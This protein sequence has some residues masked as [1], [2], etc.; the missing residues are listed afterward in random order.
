MDPTRP[1]DAVVQVESPHVAQY[2]L[3]A[4]PADQA[5]FTGFASGTDLSAGQPHPVG[6]LPQGSE[7]GV[8]FDVGGNPRTAYRVRL[9]CFQDG[10]PIPGATTVVSG[11]TDEN[12]ADSA[13]GRVTVS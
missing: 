1:L 12:G 5:A 10:A 4:R 2:R 11:T 3:F 13:T 9:S 6:P 8:A 7:I